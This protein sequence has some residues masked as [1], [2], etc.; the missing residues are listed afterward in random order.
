MNTFMPCPCND[1]HEWQFIQRPKIVYISVHLTNECQIPTKSNVKRN[2]KHFT[3][4]F[5]EYYAVSIWSQPLTSR[6]SDL[7]QDKSRVQMNENGC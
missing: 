7:Q 3:C 4:A 5:I 2:Y 1:E 6:L